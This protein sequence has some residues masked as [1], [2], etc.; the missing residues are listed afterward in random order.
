[1]SRSGYTYDCDDEGTLGLW[2]GSVTRAIRGKRSQKALMELA[3]RSAWCAAMEPYA[4]MGGRSHHPR[5]N[6]P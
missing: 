4:Q 1:M 5:Q 2:R 6:Q 3:A